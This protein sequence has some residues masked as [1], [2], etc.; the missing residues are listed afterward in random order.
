K[1][2]LSGKV[3]AG[4]FAAKAMLEGPIKKAATQG[5]GGSSFLLNFRRSYLDQTSKSIYSFVD[6]AG[7]PFKF[8]DIYGKISLN[9]ANGSKVNLFGFN[10]TDGV[11]YKGVSELNWVNNG[12]GANFVLVPSGS[13]V[14][15]DG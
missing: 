14:L 8:Q 11:K 1:T 15:I 3:G 5:D 4:T 10:F 12:G 13:S 2:R 7:L 9:S 6:S